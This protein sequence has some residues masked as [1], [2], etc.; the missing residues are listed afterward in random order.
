MRSEELDGA[1]ASSQAALAYNPPPGK[2]TWKPGYPAML[3]SMWSPNHANVVLRGA[4]MAFES[5]H[6]MTLNA[7]PDAR[8]WNA[9]F[10]AAATGQRNANGYTYAIA[11]KSL[12][13]IA[14]HLARRAAGLP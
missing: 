14:D 9:L 4:V 3:T 11:S 5:Q 6:G 7:R 8:F 10:H 13:E 12:P 2:F 1:T